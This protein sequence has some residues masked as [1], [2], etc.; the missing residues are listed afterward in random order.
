M[1][2][3]LVLAASENDIIGKGNALPWRLPADLKYFKTVTLGKPI[4]MGRKTWES[5]GKPLPDRTNIVMTRRPLQLSG[6]VVVEDVA[7]ALRAAG[8]ADELMVIGGADIFREFL[9]LAQR[10]YLT[11]VHAVIDGDVVFPLPEPAQWRELSRQDYPA[12]ERHPYPF[13]FIV[14]ERV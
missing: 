13:S 4:V 7:A 14:L 8:D 10:I 3:S 2:I 9:P 1:K 11:R 12:D 5:L 6:C